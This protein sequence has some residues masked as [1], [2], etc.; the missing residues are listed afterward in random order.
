[1]MDNGTILKAAL[2]LPGI[3]IH[4]RDLYRR[5]LPDCPGNFAAT[6][7]KV[8]VSAGSANPAGA[9]LELMNT[10]EHV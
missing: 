5:A 8:R 2:A 10:I 3:G 9:V 4:P 7:E 1:M 6:E